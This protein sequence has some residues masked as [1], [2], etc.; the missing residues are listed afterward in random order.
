MRLSDYQ[1]VHAEKLREFLTSPAGHATMTMLGL[2]RPKPEFP[3]E[4]HLL[5]ENRGAIRGYELCMAQFA[6][7]VTPVSERAPIE[8]TYGVEGEKKDD[9]RIKPQTLKP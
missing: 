7:L 8:P 6:V 9:P 2:L 1:K 4:A 3:K 5:N